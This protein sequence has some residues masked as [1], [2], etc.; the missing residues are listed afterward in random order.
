MKPYKPTVGEGRIDISRDRWRTIILRLMRAEQQI[1]EL[2]DKFRVVGEAAQASTV[3]ARAAGL[4][5]GREDVLLLIARW[6][7]CRPLEGLNGAQ[8]AEALRKVL[9]PT[10][11]PQTV[12]WDELVDKVENVSGWK[13]PT[14]Y[15]TSTEIEHLP[16]GT[17]I[18]E[19]K[20]EPDEDLFLDW[21]DAQAGITKFKAFADKW[22]PYAD[23]FNPAWE[24]EDYDWRPAGNGLEE[25]KVTRTTMEFRST[26]K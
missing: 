20:N 3:I 22:L 6:G 9:T 11:A 16:D 26:P 4:Q 19:H 21:R 18:V 24:I 25:R 1:D 17:N 14:P 23:K 15:L 10:I 8:M 12:N 5:Q 13:S 2:E 7:K